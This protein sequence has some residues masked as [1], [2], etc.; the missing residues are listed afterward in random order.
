MGGGGGAIAERFRSD[1]AP[2]GLTT[3]NTET[4][5]RTRKMVDE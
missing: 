3:E 4:A 2:F 5:L 1:S